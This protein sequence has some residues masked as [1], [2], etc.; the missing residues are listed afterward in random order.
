MK[1]LLAILL[2]AVL[3]LSFATFAS[4]EQTKPLKVAVCIAEA[5]GDLGFNDSADA[6]LKKLE[7][8]FGVQGS[9]VECKS[10]ASKY[11]TA[12][13]DAAEANDVVVAVGWQ[14]WM[15]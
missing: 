14:F 9:I 13:V 12:L 11:Q 7:A 6:G 4:A 10:D 8:D 3:L 2:S 15:R 5:L 1:K